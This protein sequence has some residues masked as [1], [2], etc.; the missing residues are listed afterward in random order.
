M[1]KRFDLDIEKSQVIEVPF[2]YEF[3][4]FGLHNDKPAIWMLIFTDQRK[5]T[6]K[7]VIFPEDV[8]IPANFNKTNYVGRFEHKAEVG[9]HVVHIFKE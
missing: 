9:H 7:F 4:G 6:E 8:E 2:N 1:I 3:L 5:M